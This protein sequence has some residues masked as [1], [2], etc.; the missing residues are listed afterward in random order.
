MSY[1]VV[2]E[3]QMKK[4]VLPLLVLFLFVLSAC[5]SAPTQSAT[6]PVETEP[7][8]EMEKTEEPAPVITT[9]PVDKNETTNEDIEEAIPVTGDTPVLLKIVPGESSVKYEV[10]ET[11]INQDNRFQVAVGIT[12]NITGEVYANPEFPPDSQVGPISVNISEFKSDSSR[13]DGV[14]RQQWLESA[15]YPIATF[16]PTEILDLPE[17]YTPGEPYSFTI[18]GDLM[19]R[20]V[21]KP[22]SFSVS[23]SFQ[24]E[25]L[26]GTAT[27][28]LLMSDFGV[29]PISILGILNTEDEVKLTFAFVARP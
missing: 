3:V 16:T 29:G 4:T 6:D 1:L 12:T 26:R 15:T 23:A 13:R 17:T 19:I 5:V 18:N 2:Q 28:T 25:T 27:T 11:F 20:E 14:I 10:G 21:T 22:V 7:V 9:E 24:E 8:M